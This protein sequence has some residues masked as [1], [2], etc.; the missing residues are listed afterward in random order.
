M[1]KNL[2]KNVLYLTEKKNQL[3]QIKMLFKKKIA[4]FNGYHMFTKAVLNNAKIHISFLFFKLL[5]INPTKIAH[6]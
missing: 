4:S 1:I 6:L 5:K 3:K 2:Q